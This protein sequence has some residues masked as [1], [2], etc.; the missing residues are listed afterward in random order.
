MLDYT[1]YPIKI[2]NLNCTLGNEQIL[3]NINLKI[4]KHKFYSII[5]PNGSGKTTLLKNISK[6]LEPDKNT[7]FIEEKDIRELKNKEL[8]KKIAYVPQNTQI[9]FDFPVM[10]L[11]LMGRAPYLKNFQNESSTDI[12]IVKNAMKLTNTWYLKDRN[13]NDISGGERQRV[14]IARALAQQT[15]I[16]L[17]DEPISNLDIHH[18]ISVLDTIK[19]L[20]IEKNITV[21]TVLHDLSIAAQYSDYL[22]LMDKGKLQAQGIPEDVLTAENIKKVYDMDILILK[23]PITQKPYIIPVGKSF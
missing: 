3:Y 15:D 17:L 22:I 8:A 20:N 12:D 5:G 13:I 10:D 2:N 23:N 4:E 21:V 9:D 7:I 1:M 11:V 6:A 19:T 14:L 18:Q 16:L